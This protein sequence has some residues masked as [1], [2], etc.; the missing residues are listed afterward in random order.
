MPFS[1]LKYLKFWVSTKTR[2]EGV[3]GGGPTLKELRITTSYPRDPAVRSAQKGR[4]LASAQGIIPLGY[5][6]SL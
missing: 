1:L 3:N 6:Q 4:H 5:D 2:H